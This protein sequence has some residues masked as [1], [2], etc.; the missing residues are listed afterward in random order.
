MGGYFFYFCFLRSLHP[1][2]VALKL[3]ECQHQRTGSE[4]WV[5][6]VNRSVGGAL[7]YAPGQDL[8]QKGGYLFPF[9]GWQ[10]E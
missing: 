2:E 7:V 10:V 6:K 8:Y 5:N 3:R 9:K 4:Y 1:S